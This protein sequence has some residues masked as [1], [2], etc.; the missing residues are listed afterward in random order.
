M[1]RDSDLVKL[2]PIVNFNSDNLKKAESFQNKTLRPI[3]KFQNQFLLYNF[4]N[5]IK[6]K[7]PLFNAYNA[8]EQ[9]KIIR[10]SV[11]EDQRLKNHLLSSVIA[12]FTIEELE[13]YTKNSKE[14][15]KRIVSMII[16]RVE[17][18]ISTLY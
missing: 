10:K 13:F 4:K 16:Q 12:Y 1:T 6:T 17:D 5:F 7:E 3:L 15:S 18:Q 14:I 2:R 8:L 9:K 11:K